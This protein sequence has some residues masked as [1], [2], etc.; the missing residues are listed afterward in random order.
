[1]P[2]NR[3][4]AWLGFSYGCVLF[5]FA[6]GT[7]GMGHGTYLPFA[8]YGAP[9]SIFPIAGLFVA[10]VWWA[11]LGWM[12]SSGRRRTAFVML[13]SHLTGVALLLWFGTPMEH[14]EDQWTYVSKVQ[15]A[16]PVWLWS[17]LAVYTVGLLFS[18]VTVFKNQVRH[19]DR[20]NDR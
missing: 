11:A 3:R 1:M 9:F 7:S 16:L 14:G 20:A 13:A 15:R 18:V 4:W 19:S 6:F 5:L 2:R 12:L 8:I 17:G 10:P